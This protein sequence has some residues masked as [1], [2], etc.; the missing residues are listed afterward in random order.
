MNS[1]PPSPPPLPP[2]EEEGEGAGDGMSTPPPSKRDKEEPPLEESSFDLVTFE[3]TEL[4]KTLKRDDPYF[5][6]LTIDEKVQLIS[7]VARNL[8]E[9]A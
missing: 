7:M 3:F 8:F 1:P 2:K 9:T 5:K 4:F 6:K